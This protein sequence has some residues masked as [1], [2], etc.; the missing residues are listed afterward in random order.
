ME[1]YRTGRAAVEGICPLLMNNGLTVDELNPWTIKVNDITSKPKKQKTA[2]DDLKIAE[3]KFNG[4]LYVD[5]KDGPIIPD[6]VLEAVIRDGAK[7]N[8]NG[9]K[10]LAG[11]QVDAPAP[12]I[13][14]GPRTRKALFND[15]NFVDRR[16]VVINRGSKV[17]ATR[18]RFN[19]WAVEFDVNILEDVISTQEVMVALEKAGKYKAMCDYRPKFGRFMVTKFDWS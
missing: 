18:P 17:I 16:V 15:K 5:D 7:M 13:Y 2:Q 10:V 4:A 9:Q 11:L 8:S 14:D 1:G 3:Y 6:Y 12:L 19:A